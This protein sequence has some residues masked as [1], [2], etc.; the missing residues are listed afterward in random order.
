VG[1]VMG[2]V[3]AFECY[4][5]WVRSGQTKFGICLFFPKHTVWRAKTG[6]LGL[7]FMCPSGATC[8]PAHLFFCLASNDRVGLV[9]NG[10]NH[11]LSE[12]N[13][14]HPFTHT[15]VKQQLYK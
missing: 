10:Q 11:Y 14:N 4:R 12:G 6:W 1:D 8:L 15:L 2:S 5:S 7:M 9:H 3:I 13:K